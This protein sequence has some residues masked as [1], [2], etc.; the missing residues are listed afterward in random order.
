[1]SSLAAIIFDT[2]SSALDIAIAAILESQSE[3]ATIVE[4]QSRLNF[5]GE[6]NP[7]YFQ[8]AGNNVGFIHSQSAD[9][10]RLF[11]AFQKAYPGT[12]RG[13]KTEFESFQRTLG[14]TTKNKKAAMESILPKLL[15]ALE[16]QKAQ[17]AEMMQRSLSDRRVIVPSWPGLARWLND[18]RWEQDFPLYSPSAAGMP[19]TETP[20]D[21]LYGKYIAHLKSQPATTAII[22]D[23]RQLSKED[24]NDWVN[25]TGRF[26]KN[27]QYLAP[28]E[29][30]QF[31]NRIHRDFKD[32]KFATV[33]D[34]LMAEY[35]KM[36]G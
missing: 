25:D 8:I 18:K 9:N 20:D 32:T 29:K 35:K 12:K 11:D 13:F 16:K 24:F 28:A 23:G 26:N 5:T 22:F 1:M 31:F 36:N 2:E 3:V 10:D 15:P 19:T 30:K 6:I 33:I 17:R 34:F 14:K 27:P 21:E 7:K 4:L